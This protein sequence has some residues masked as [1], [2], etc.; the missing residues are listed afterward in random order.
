MS[1][2]ICAQH[3]AGKVQNEVHVDTFLF[4][5]NFAI[6]MVHNI[7]CTF[8]FYLSSWGKSIFPVEH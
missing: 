8:V 4:C 7:L 1:T 5:V 6:G 2:P 3:F